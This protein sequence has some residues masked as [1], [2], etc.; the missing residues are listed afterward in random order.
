MNYRFHLAELDN[1]GNVTREVTITFQSEY[2][3]IDDVPEWIRIEIDP[4]ANMEEK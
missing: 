2:T 1:S 4:T 3:L